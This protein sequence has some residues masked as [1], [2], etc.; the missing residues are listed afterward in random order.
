MFK[1][2]LHGDAC[3]ADPRA[4]ALLTCRWADTAEKGAQIAANLPADADLSVQSDSVT[5]LFKA[6]K[7]LGLN[8]MRLFGHGDGDFRLQTAAGDICV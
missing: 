3:G 6:A 4:L 5:S 8:T 2:A 7:V 1:I